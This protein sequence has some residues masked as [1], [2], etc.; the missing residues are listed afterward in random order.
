MGKFF[1]DVDEV[2]IFFEAVGIGF[3]AASHHD[4]AEDV[5]ELIFVETMTVN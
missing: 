5:G 2:F 1:D 3:G 4:V